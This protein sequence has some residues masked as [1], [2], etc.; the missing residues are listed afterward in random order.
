MFDR[1]SLCKNNFLFTTSLT[2]LKLYIIA[3]LVM[4]ILYWYQLF[5][6]LDMFQLYN[7]GLK[8][9]V[10]HCSYPF[11]FSYFQISNKTFLVWRILGPVKP[12]Q[13]LFLVLIVRMYIMACSFL[14]FN[15]YQT[16][17]LVLECLSIAQTSTNHKIEF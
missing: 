15:I 5:M 4:C 14:M 16:S 1:L 13:L 7:L 2:L 12:S 3:N 9:A 10:Q 17:H 11:F 6:I 8:L